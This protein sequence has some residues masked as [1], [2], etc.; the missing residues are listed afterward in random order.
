MESPSWSRDGYRITCNP[1]DIDRDVVI[2][3]LSSS[4]WARDLG[5]DVIG[6]SLDHSLCFSLRRGTGQ[7]GF[8]RVITDYARFAHLADVFVLRE[9]QG[10][11]LGKWLVSCVLEHPELG[12]VRRW[13]LGTDDAHEFYSQLGFAPLREPGKYMERQRN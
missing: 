12:D 7:I 6:R 13:T 3:F 2:A 10:K 11:G 8:A 5:T 4:Y 9:H 1:A